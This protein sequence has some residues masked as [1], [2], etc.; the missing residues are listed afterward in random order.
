M[1][2]DKPRWRPYLQYLE[3]L[4]KRREERGE[5]PAPDAAPPEYWQRRRELEDMKNEKR[6]E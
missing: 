6:D 5:P 2:N 3:Q 4:G 1:T